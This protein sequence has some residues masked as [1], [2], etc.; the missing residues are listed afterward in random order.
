MNHISYD[1]TSLSRHPY[2][3]SFRCKSPLITLLLLS[4]LLSGNGCVSPK[5]IVY[6][7]GEAET[8]SAVRMPEAYTPLIKTGDVL[9]IQVSSLNAEAATFFN[10]YT[11]ML[12]AN[13]RTVQPSNTS[14]LPE[15]S[16][17]LVSPDGEIELPLIGSIKVSGLTISQ[18]KEQVRDKLKTYLKEPTVNIRNLNFRISVLGEVVRPSLF[19]VPNDQITLIEAIS[20]AGDAT[21]YGRRDNIL[22]VREENGQK[23]FSRLDIT[24]RN[25]FRS[26]Y[27]YLHPNDIVYVEP[28]KVRVSTANQ[29]YQVIPAIL[30][31]LSLVAI[32]VTRR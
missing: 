7:Q 32:I 23:T 28:G 11:P 1:C 3:R 29:F 2:W 22:V 8:G 31:A 25:L 4:V 5:S 13:G 21:I 15:M 14:G 6:F 12:V 26:P 18:T 17:Y 20:L 10:P 19:T 30:S 24:K 16:G 27:Y 9:S